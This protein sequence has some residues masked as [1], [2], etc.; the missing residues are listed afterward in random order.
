MEIVHKKYE[1]K[2]HLFQKIYYH[3]G[4]LIEDERELRASFNT[5]N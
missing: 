5:N 2:T 4:L 3:P 1:A